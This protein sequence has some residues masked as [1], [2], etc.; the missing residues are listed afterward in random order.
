MLSGTSCSSAPVKEPPPPRVQRAPATITT[1]AIHV[2]Q[3]ITPPQTP[4]DEW[5][6]RHMP[7]Y[8]A[9]LRQEVQAQLQH[10]GFTVIVDRKTPADIV[11]TIQSD[12]PHERTGVATM[13]LYRRG[14]MIDRISVPIA[15]WGASPRAVH[16]IA[17]ASVQLVEAL[18]RSTAVAAVANEVA[19]KEVVK[20]VAPP[21]V[22]VASAAT[23]GSDEC[24]AVP[25]AAPEP[26]APIAECVTERRVRCQPPSPVTSAFQIAPFAECPLQIPFS[27]TD[28][29]QQGGARF[30]A[31]ETRARRLGGACGAPPPSGECCYVQF[32][33]TFCR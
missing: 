27:G 30:S 33:P 4:D 25:G 14:Q 9:S 2:F 23:T 21:A 18:E 24:P 29:L 22:A 3:N 20:L 7:G 16:M 13:V 31:G 1:L 8:T 26:T 6:Y 19:G 10:A 11:A 5:D 15:V 32:D 28:V 12:M 17:H